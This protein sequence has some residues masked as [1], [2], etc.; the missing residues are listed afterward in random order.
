MSRSDRPYSRLDLD[1]D[2]TKWT[3]PFI[4]DHDQGVVNSNNRFRTQGTD[5]EQPRFELHYPPT[6]EHPYFQIGGQVYRQPAAYTEAR[7][8]M[9]EENPWWPY[10]YPSQSSPR[11]DPPSTIITLD[12][13]GKPV[14]KTSNSFQPNTTIIEDEETYPNVEKRGHDSLRSDDGWSDSDEDTEMDIDGGSGHDGGHNNG[15]KQSMTEDRKRRKL[16]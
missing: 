10:W 14:S 13:Q 5:R 9:L 11:P 16:G 7:R 8:K 3:M 4:R 1:H 6:Q 15:G 12:P 2:V